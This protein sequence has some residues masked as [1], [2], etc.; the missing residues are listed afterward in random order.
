MILKMIKRM[1]LMTLTVNPRFLVRGA[2][3]KS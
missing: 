1:T 2:N 3:G